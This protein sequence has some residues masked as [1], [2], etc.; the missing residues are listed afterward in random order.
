MGSIPGLSGNIPKGVTLSSFQQPAYSTQQFEADVQS[1]G[2]SVDSVSPDYIPYDNVQSGG[3]GG[4][5]YVAPPPP[6]YRDVYGNA[7]SSQAEANESNAQAALLDSQQGQLQSMLGRTDNTLNQ[8]LTSIND[9]FNRESTRTNEQRSRALEDFG[10]RRED[11]VRNKNTNINKVNTNARTLND[12]VRR[13]LGL[14]SGSG[15]SAY[16]LAA[17]GAV[18]RTATLNRT[19]VLENYAKND[20]NITVAEDRAKVDFENLLADL[21]AQKNDKERSLRQGVLENQQDINSKLANI[22][23]QRAAL[24]GG[25][26]AQVKNAI[27]PYQDQ[28]NQRSAQLDSLFN[29]FR[30]ATYN[31]KPVEVQKPDL[32]DYMV[33][34]AAIAQNTGPQSQYNP[35]SAFLQP[36]KE[37]QNNPLVG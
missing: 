29:Q 2:L 20:R 22:A 18:A 23:A 3:G 14:A 30:N 12:S 17:P 10:I 15:S 13:I 36:K 4:G 27:A 11:D 1:G 32:K 19:G 34:R 33:D 8:G 21:A 37:E 26:Y 16:Q 9:S 5:G 25:G 31:V 7:Y 24:Q 35:Y 28:I 6:V